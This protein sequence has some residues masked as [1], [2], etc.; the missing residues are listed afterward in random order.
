MHV[1]ESGVDFVYTS[2]GYG[3]VISSA[4][5]IARGPCRLVL[6]SEAQLGVSDK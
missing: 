4:L 1:F 3:A 6:T 5:E 2:T